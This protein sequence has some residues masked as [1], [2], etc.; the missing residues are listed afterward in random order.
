MCILWGYII[1][2]L[3]QIMSSRENKEEKK[4]TCCSSE[5]KKHHHG[6]GLIVL[7]LVV[8]ILTNLG[9]GYY[10]STGT[11][12]IDAIA[13]AVMDKYF[14]NEYQKAGGKENYNLLTKAQRLQMQ[15][16]ISQIKQFIASKEGGAAQPNTENTGGETPV[17]VTKTLTQDEIAA[18]KSTAYI[19]GNKDAII[20]LVEYSDLEC[21]FCIRQFK[22]GTIEKIREEYGDKVNSMFKNFRGVPHTNSEVEANALLCAGDIG[23][24]DKY[25]AYYSAI[26]TRT[27]GGNG[28]GFAADALLPL[29]KELKIDGK[30]FQACMDSKK[31]ITRFD[32]ETAEGAKLGVQGTPGTVVINNQTGEYELI[33]GAYPVSEFQ[34]VIN[35]LLGAK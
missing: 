4:N 7:L 28:T 17:A 3:F 33:A 15:D 13:S 10:L 21:P 23:G 19:E 14:D 12:N 27:N 26:F 8:S 34:R 16:Q 32:T 5:E 25:V 35:K 2:Y 31:N 22:D 18:I 29:A 30:K 9:T 6:K 1:S 24:T 20:T 11:K